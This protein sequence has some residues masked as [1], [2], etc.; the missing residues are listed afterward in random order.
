MIDLLEII[1]ELC[2]K[3]AKRNPKILLVATVAIISGSMMRTYDSHQIIE[4]LR[5]ENNSLEAQLIPFKTVALEKYANLAE[6]KALAEL[7]TRVGQ[8]EL[9]LINLPQ[10]QEVASWDARGKVH[11]VMAGGSAIARGPS[12]IADWNKGYW[13]IIE[14]DLSEVKCDSRAID[15]YLETIKQAPLYPFAQYS[16]A[17][18]LKEKRMKDGKLIFKNL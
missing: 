12:A 13:Q 15:K 8:T 6:E 3:W 1:K 16:M 10:Y 5:D 2:P 17:V 11:T 9:S 14:G 7:A 4:P 18:C